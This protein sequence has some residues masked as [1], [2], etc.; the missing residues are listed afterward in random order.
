V[1]IILLAGL[2]SILLAACGVSPKR[3]EP[4]QSVYRAESLA[5]Q[6]RRE[7]AAALYWDSAEAA[8]PEA[9]FDLRLRAVETL[10]T[11]QT[12]A[13]ARSYLERIGRAGLPPDQQVRLRL[14]EARLALLEGRPQRALAL[15]PESPPPDLD[16]ALSARLLDL[17]AEILAALGR[18]EQAIALRIRLA[19]EAPTAGLR[20][21]DEDALWDLLRTLPPE[22]LDA[23]RRQLQDPVL[24]GWCALAWI[25]TQ[26]GDEASLAAAIETWRNRH[27]GHPAARRFPQRILS[28]WRALRVQPRQVAVLLPLTGRLAGAGNAIA[29]GL[30]AAYYG[31]PGE[32]ALRF[33]DTA[34]DPARAVTAYAR[35]TAEGADAVIGPLSKAAVRRLAA[36]VTITVPTLTLNY[37]PDAEAATPDNLYQFGLLPEDEAREIA[38]RMWREGRRR[39]VA[40]VAEGGWGQRMLRALKAGLTEYD[41]VLLDARA[42]TGGQ[43]DFSGVI[44]Q[45]LLLD[46]SRAR[47]N[48][49][50][51]VL[52][53]EIRFE[54][55]RRGDVEVIA[56]AAPPVQARLLHPQLRFYFS[57]D[58]P[59]Y[60]TSRVYTGR[61]NPFADADLNGVEFCDAPL[62]L[63]ST[64]QARRVRA[65][66][67]QAVPEAVQRLPRLAAL[68][69]D[70][71]ILLPQVRVLES[72]S[73]SALAGV[74]GRLSMGSGRRV[75]RELDWARFEEGRAVPL[76]SLDART[77]PAPSGAEAVPD[78]RLT[79]A[80]PGAPLQPSP[81]PEPMPTDTSPTAGSRPAR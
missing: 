12:R 40:F 5:A 70:A 2:A 32:E 81:E 21:A 17:R 52:R 54:P 4:P 39:A 62:V 13:Q 8:P 80:A 49:L 67:E 78:T 28:D 65:A 74:T 30:L 76:S 56:L 47:Y 41:G 46:E 44:Q 29:E 50:R 48:R 25:P 72:R 42:L 23:C 43:T 24:A 69:Y 18:T 19:R 1:R 20:E 10:L 60:A 14:A 64:E 38:R 31:R 36:E 7:E 45:A 79:P 57:G 35:A 27:P 15:L 3:W 68:G 26:S 71:W 58:L 16:P 73:A 34:S 61:P 53:R 22:R 55:R 75:I 37:L 77:S 6:G 11:P 9:A 63:G 59:V 51:A 66:L 33:Y